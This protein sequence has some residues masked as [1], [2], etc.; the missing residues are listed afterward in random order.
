[1]RRLVIRFLAF[2]VLFS[3]LVVL[4][5]SIEKLTLAFGR[6]QPENYAALAREALAKG[7]LEDAKKIV[8]K[9]LS[10]RF[11]D[12][13]ALYLLAEIQARGGDDSA[14]ANT[15]RE[16]F[17][18]FPGA[19]SNPVE[20]TGYD[21]PKTYYLFANYLWRA[22]R[23]VDAAEMA[24]AAIDAGYPMARETAR[25]YVQ[26][27]SLA[28]DEAEAVASLAFKLRQPQAFLRAVEV[29]RRDPERAYRAE[30]WQALWM[31]AID[32]NLVGAELHL[33]AA[34]TQW[35]E[36]P[37][38]WL[39]LG[40]LHRR[41]STPTSGD[42][43]W[44][45]RALETTG[46]KV[47]GPGLFKLSAGGASRPGAIAMGR[48]GTARARVATGAYRVTRLIVNASGTWAIGMYPVIVVRVNEKELTR[49][50]LDGPHPHLFDLR[51][52]P[53]G[54]PKDISLEFE[55]VND[56]YEPQ[57]KA[58]RNVIIEDVVLF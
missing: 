6:S 32:R 28:P 52:W 22:K 4:G 46:A 31:E 42:D 43:V 9:R 27:A 36:E 40:N 33:R 38:L 56:A 15:I 20:A 44:R 16:V 41:H 34:T 25:T 53:Q 5:S 13:D 7:R 35:P 58:D 2:A 48:N 3:L 17:L 11:Y 51:L 23:F 55:F 1:M 10:K 39:A 21:E 14:A 26:E 54:A 12:F 49:L 18:R 30:V 29:L 47:L 50:Y 8:E 19:R 24:R 37:T 45:R 57:S